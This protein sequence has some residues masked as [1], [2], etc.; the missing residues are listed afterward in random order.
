MDVGGQCSTSN[1][2]RNKPESEFL[3]GQVEHTL[4]HERLGSCLAVVMKSNIL[5]ECGPL[6]SMSISHPPDVIHM[7]SILR[8]FLFFTA[9]PLLCVIPG[10]PEAICGW[11][12]PA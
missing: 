12:G 8:S 3:T 7:I 9:L 6:P 2:V 1:F 4:S 5:F 10:M 11:S